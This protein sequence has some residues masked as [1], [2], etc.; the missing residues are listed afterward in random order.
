M[1]TREPR[2]P[3][4]FR[5]VYDDGESFSAATVRN[6]SATGLLLETPEPAA[7]G[8][9]VTLYSVESAAQQLAGIRARVVRI[10]PEDP[11]RSMLPCMALEFL[12]PSQLRP[13]LDLLIDALR[14]RDK[15]RVWD[16][17]LGAP[18]RAARRRR[19]TARDWTATTGESSLPAEPA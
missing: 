3:F 13:L 2:H 4:T 15:S 1:R 18:I 19:E 5:L 16:L 6:L 7:P 10:V 8:S 14:T 9:E 12:D 11:D 17:M